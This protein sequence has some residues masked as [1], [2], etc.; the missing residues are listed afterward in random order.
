MC[1]VLE[2]GGVGEDWRVLVCMGYWR[3]EVMRGGREGLGG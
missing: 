3:V 2:C 1:R